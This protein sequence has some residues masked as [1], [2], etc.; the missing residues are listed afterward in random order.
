MRFSLP[1]KTKFAIGQWNYKGVWVDSK[2]V[3]IGKIEK[4]SH[5]SRGA[6]RT[7]F[8]LRYLES[9]TKNTPSCQVWAISVQLRNF[10]FFSSKIPTKI[11]KKV[12]FVWNRFKI[13]RKVYFWVLILNIWTKKLSDVHHVSYGRFSQFLLSS[14]FLDR[15][16]HP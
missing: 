14:R 16:K 1:R 12:I 4:N 6:H 5:N 11:W 9:S 15:P 7:I 8:S 2:S 3:T 10:I 13:G